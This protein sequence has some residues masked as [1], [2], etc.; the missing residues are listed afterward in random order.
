MK[1]AY[2]YYPQAQVGKVSPP[3]PMLVW[4]SSASRAQGPE[5]LKVSE[6]LE[7]IRSEALRQG[8][9]EIQEALEK[10]R[11]EIWLSAQEIQNTEAPSYNHITPKPVLSVKC[12]YKFIGE[13]KPRHF[14]IDE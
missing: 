5:A 12:R 1:V 14:P 3:Y 4:P 9:Q 6:A 7:K 10:I 8:M 13:M 2:S 11:S